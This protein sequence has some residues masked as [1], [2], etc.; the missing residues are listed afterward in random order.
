M[1]ARF[2]CGQRVSRPM[3]RSQAST[4][5]RAGDF[6]AA[7]GEAFPER[8]AG[9]GGGVVAFGGAEAAHGVGGERMNRLTGD[10]ESF[11]ERR[12][13]HGCAGLL[14]EDAAAA[15][16]AWLPGAAEAAA[17]PGPE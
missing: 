3:R 9:A 15:V 1:G 7:H 6:L 4:A 10:V 16:R 13:D 12:H 11:G 2:S 5:G 14:T 17:G 8:R